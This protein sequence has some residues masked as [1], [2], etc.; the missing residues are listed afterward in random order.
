MAF[1]GYDDLIERGPLLADMLAVVQPRPIPASGN[2]DERTIKVE[3]MRR[4]GE[5]LSP[6][7]R[8]P[9]S[10][11]DNRSKD[12]DDTQDDTIDRTLGMMTERLLDGE[13][14]ES[15]E[16]VMATIF[17][18][19]PV[20]GRELEAIQL[21]ERANAITFHNL[22]DTIQD[23]MLLVIS[24]AR[25]IYSLIAHNILSNPKLA[26]LTPKREHLEQAAFGAS[27]AA[28]IVPSLLTLSRM[29]KAST[30]IAAHHPELRPYT[31]GLSGQP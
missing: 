2:V 3:R 14:I 21:V 29:K 19:E 1:R 30:E 31:P 13:E 9:V 5:L 22:Q 20:P 26:K 27:C 16:E 25:D 15:A 23:D 28:I 6:L 4:R 17:E 10:T 24:T 12:E 11:F 18:A 7:K 8:E